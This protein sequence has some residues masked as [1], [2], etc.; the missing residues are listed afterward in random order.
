MSFR[1]LWAGLIA[2]GA[3]RAPLACDS[4]KCT[5]GDPA[6]G[7]ASGITAGH[8][9]H[10]DYRWSVDTSY[11]YK[12]W[13]RIKPSHALAIND[14]AGRHTHAVIDEWTAS[15]RVGYAVTRDVELGLTQGYRHVRQ[16][17]GTDPLFAGAH[18]TSNGIDDLRFDFRW[19]FKRQTE[20][21]W[22]VDLALFG[23]GLFPTGQVHERGANEARIEA[24]HQ[25]GTGGFAGT[26]GL[27]VSRGWNRWGAS[28]SVAY[29]HKTE[30]TQDY[31]PGDVLR[32]S[33][34]GSYRVSPE[35]W[36]TKIWL[37]LG[38]QAL[39]ENKSQED[40]EKDPNHGGQT[41][42]VIPGLAVQP[43]DRLIFSASLQQPVYQ[44]L[45]GY[46]Q[47]EDWALAFNTRVRF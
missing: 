14:T 42:F 20:S 30:G 3:L 6:R 13:D 37:N 34:A 41:I 23:E 18:E 33:A 38:V 21:G 12:N 9:H 24:E 11:H 39:F 46:H 28:G 45:N 31:K 5:A 43:L 44:Q 40:G 32:V 47:E 26:L 27:A 35:S 29:T 15:I 1:F 36:G 22:P 19:R 25:P 8:E 2:L 16:Q 17:N 4:C 10:E 7:G